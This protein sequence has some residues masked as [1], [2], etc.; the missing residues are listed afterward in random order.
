MRNRWLAFSVLVVL[1]LSNL[2][3]TQE[4]SGTIRGYVFLDSNRNGIFDAGEEGVSGVNVTISYDKY[5]HTYHTGAGDPEGNVPGPGSYGPTPLQRGTWTVTLGVP[6]GYR[7]TTPTELEV[8]IPDDG[9]AT[10]VNLG[11]YGSGPISYGGG[12]AAGGAS[13]A[14]GVTTLPQTG[15]TEGV[16]IGQWV[17]LL[18]VLA[19]FLTLI[20]TPWCV[21]RVKRVPRRWW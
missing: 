17:A 5:S 4:S 2:G 20:G 15:G 13:G 14:T 1:V 6:D 3:A 18:A 10:G 11:I 8:T 7:A 16:I 9:S 19:G 21:A 12:P